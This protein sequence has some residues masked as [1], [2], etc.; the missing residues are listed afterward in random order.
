MANPDELV[1]KDPE[2]ILEI[3]RT[4]PLNPEEVPATRSDLV[5][6][7]S[8]YMNGK[9]LSG[10]QSIKLDYDIERPT[11]L[12]TVSMVVKRDSIKINS[13]KIMFDE[14]NFNG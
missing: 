2:T 14:V 1:P 5:F 6:T 12:V 4:F 9:K 3:V 8:V 11:T 10:V 13:D 7:K